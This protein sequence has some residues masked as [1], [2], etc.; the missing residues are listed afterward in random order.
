MSPR[1]AL[2]AVL[3]QIAAL[4]LASPL[5]ISATEGRANAVDVSALSDG[6]LEPR[7]NGRFS[8][9]EAEAL[10][11]SWRASEKRRAIVVLRELLDLSSEDRDAELEARASVRLGDLYRGLGQARESLAF[12]ERALEGSSADP[13]VSIEARIGAARARLRLDDYRGGLRDAQTALELSRSLG[14]RSLEI[15]ALL[16]L[17]I[18]RYDSRD[19]VGALGLFEGS[20]RLAETLRDERS[21]AL[22][23]LYLGSTHSDIGEEWRAIPAS[24]LALRI[25][26]RLGEGGLEPLALMSLGHTYSK[27]GEKQKALEY[28]QQAAPLLEEMGDLHESASLYTG[29][30]YLYDD[31]GDYENA[32]GFYRHAFRLSEIAGS[33]YGEAGNLLHLGRVEAAMSQHS[34]ALDHLRASLARLRQVGNKQLESAALGDIALVSYALGQEEEALASYAKALALTREN[35]YEREEADILDGIAGIDLG[36]G[37]LAEARQGLHRALSLSRKTYSPFTEV[38][39]LFSLA[40]V[41][42]QGGDLDAALSRTEEALGVVETLRGRIS[43]HRLRASYVASVHDLHALHVDLLMDLH[44]QRPHVG[45]EERAFLAAERARARS[46]LDMLIEADAQESG[47]VDRA[48]LEYQKKLEERVRREASVS[49]G[50]PLLDSSSD[51]GAASLDELL[52]ELDRVRAVLRNRHSPAWH[53]AP[54]PL[55]GVR[56]LQ[57]FLDDR[58]AVLAYFLGS[59]RSYLWVITSSTV[60][61]HR[62]PSKARVE[63]EARELYRD[64]TQR[65]GEAGE[66]A[67]QRYERM[68]ELDRD[69]WRV[70]SS[71]ART[72]L[73]DAVRSLDATRLVVIAD[74]AL[75]QIPFSAL[76][77]PGLSTPEA[78]VPLVAR[79]EVVRLPSASILKALDERHGTRAGSR[80]KLAVLADPVLDDLDPRLPERRNEGKEP[81]FSSLAVRREASLAGPSGRDTVSPAPSMSRLLATRQE[82]RSILDLVPSN[83]RF[84]ALGFD[85]SRTL[86]TSGALR[87]Y[88]VVHFATH[89]ILNAERPELSGIV[90]SL[91]DETGRHQDGFLRLHDIYNLDLP[92]RLIVLSACATGLGKAIRGEGLVGLVG[93]FLST[94]SLGVIASY[95]DVDDEATAELMRRFYSDMFSGGQSPPGA[96]QSAQRSMWQERRWVSPA[97]WA[98]FE[99]QGDWR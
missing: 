10:S 65:E 82:A 70:A 42:R 30:G 19:L 23:S 4:V 29:M 97:F 78:P 24:E 6:A 34:E 80:K 18:A 38:R 40:Q 69:Y 20:L 95:W 83:E 36:H 66:T 93:G 17:G 79:Y 63:S 13:S 98:A 52:A 2:L 53:R 81:A 87:N 99:F 57:K 16:A 74:G 58:T 9:A 8:L 22:A 7:A 46:L 67:K 68:K 45:F 21:R 60:A 91:F 31:L 32:R 75:H 54:P 71:V 14:D 49:H 50:R 26:R 77:Y 73:A 88:D 86:V 37:R 62:L 5:S 1:T 11:R 47:G 92:A 35:G 33:V 90:L 85:A 84:Q 76:P 89:G 3:A 15:R 94:G 48:L 12:Y 64:L 59:P 28:Y 56:E 51:G 44:G 25:S 43:S 39:V 96:L 55:V 27:I 41:E 72:L 61:V